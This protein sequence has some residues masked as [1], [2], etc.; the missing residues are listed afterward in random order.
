MREIHI[1]LVGAGMIGRAHAAAYKNMPLV[2][3]PAP[4]V[5]VLDMIADIDRG[6][7]ESAAENMGFRRW[8]G[9]WRELVNDPAI[10]AV[11]IAATNNVHAE[12]AIAAAQAGKPI[13]CEKPLAMDAAEAREMVAAAEASGQ[14]TLVGFNYLKL[15]ALGHAHELVRAG[16][17]GEL[18]LFR[19]AYDQDVMT[20]PTVPFNWRHDAALAGT[21][22]LGDMAS[23]VLSIAKFLVG[24]IAEVCAAMATLIEQ[25]PVAGSGTGHTARAAA[26]GAM[27]RVENDDMTHVLARFENGAMGTIGASRLG[28]GRKHALTIEIQGTKGAIWFT[29]ERRNELNLYRHTDPPAERGYKLI[30]P[31]PGQPGYGPFH[32][33]PGVTLSGDDSKLIEARAFIE[34]V[35]AG[36][37]AVP[38][39]RFGL[40]V[41]EVIDAVVKSAGERRWVAVGEIAAAAA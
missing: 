41:V 37:P 40:H 8:T 7:A 22:A 10:D 23:H 13:Y 14:T 30:P 29:L 36:A 32:P 16:E 18:M 31:N 9:D 5:P 3:G 15:P 2:F 39:F 33:I 38:D 4:A 11:D 35:A 25:R 26:G 24:D 27:R 28:T 17:L 20:D 19:G 21:G 34:G 12:I 1:G 6:R